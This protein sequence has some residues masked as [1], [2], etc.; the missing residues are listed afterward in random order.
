MNP[1][2]R[3]TLTLALPPD[4]ESK[5]LRHAAAT[6]K[7]PAA[8][9]QE[10]L[11]EKLASF[12]EPRLTAAQRAAAWDGWVEHMRSWADNNLPRRHRVDDSRESIYEGRGE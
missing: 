6:G 10:T 2:T 4:V 8:F 12:S 9:V 7:D 11:E 1:E 5:L 3:M